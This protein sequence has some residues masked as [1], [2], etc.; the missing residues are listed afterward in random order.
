LNCHSTI[1]LEYPV[2]FALVLASGDSDVTKVTQKIPKTV[3]RVQQI[4]EEHIK[5]YCSI[6]ERCFR[7]D[8][9]GPNPTDR[10]GKLGT[11]RHVLAADKKG[12]P[13]SIVIITAA[14]TH[15][16]KATAA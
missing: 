6:E 10:E 12:V 15:D 3:Y 2:I 13:L 4:V 16:M 11:K 14:N 9:I 5:R 7:G 8:L 1:E